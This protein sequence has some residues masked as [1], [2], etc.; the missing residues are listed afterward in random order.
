MFNN[1]PLYSLVIDKSLRKL[2]AEHLQT[3]LTKREENSALAMLTAH[4]SYP[5]VDFI[6]FMNPL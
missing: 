6:A 2:P 3:A 4:F 5:L 1:S